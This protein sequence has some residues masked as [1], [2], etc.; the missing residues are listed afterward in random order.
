MTALAQRLREAAEAGFLSAHVK[1]TRD[2][3]VYWRHPKEGDSREPLF[4]VERHP[5]TGMMACRPRFWFEAELPTVLVNGGGK[6]EGLCV[7]GPTRE[8]AIRA[9]LLALADREEAHQ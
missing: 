1:V 7:S 8:A 5:K 4:Y 2:G 3:V 6:R 9:G